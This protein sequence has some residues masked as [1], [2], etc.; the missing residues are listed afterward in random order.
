MPTSDCLLKACQNIVVPNKTP[1]KGLIRLCWRFSQRFGPG[2]QLLELPMVA[3]A[4]GDSIRTG[5]ISVQRYPES[6]QSG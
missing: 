2:L 3:P 5:S 4:D 6:S 1:S